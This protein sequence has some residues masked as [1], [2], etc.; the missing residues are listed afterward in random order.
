MT[1]CP[2]VEQPDQ[3]SATVRVTALGAILLVALAF[4]GVPDRG[5]VVIL[6]GSAIVTHIIIWKSIVRHPHRAIAMVTI[7][8]VLA[9]ATSWVIPR[10][11]AAA[12]SAIAA[13]LVWCGV[14]FAGRALAILGAISSLGLAGSAIVHD[15]PLWVPIL[16]VTIIAG[17]AH[18]QNAMALART[19]RVLGERLSEVMSI[20]GV[21]LHHRDLNKGIVESIV[22]PIEAMTG[23]SAG[24]WETIDHRG[25]I[26]PDDLADYWID[27][28]SARPGEVFDRTARYRHRN[29]SWVWLRDVSR[30]GV[31]ESGSFGLNGFTID[32]TPVRE[33][34]SAAEYRGTHDQ[35]TDL[36]NRATLLADLE[37]RQVGGSAFGLLFLDL[38]RF[39]EV[40]DTLGHQ[41]GDQLLVE[42]AHVLRRQIGSSELVARL[43][44]DEFAVVVEVSDDRSLRERAEQVAYAARQPIS[45]GSMSLAVS[46]SIGGV[47]AADDPIDV[48]TIMRWADIAMYDAKRHGRPYSS[49][50]TDLETSS[51][52]DLLLSAS[53]PG[54]L[55]A[56]EIIAHF[57]PKIDLQT[58]M[59]VGLEALAR[60]QHP[61]HGLLGAA[62]F[63]HLIRVSDYMSA[64]T[65]QMIDIALKATIALE[66][67]GTT[68][69]IAVNIAA[70]TL[71]DNGFPERVITRCQ[72][73]GVEPSR[74]TFE[75]TEDE[76]IEAGDGARQTIVQLHDA[77]IRFSVDDFGTGYSSFSLLPSMP[78]DEIKIDRSF[79]WGVDDE[80]RNEVI[81]ASIIGL[82]HGLGHR[83][84]AEGVETSKQLDFLIGLGCDVGQGYLFGRPVTLAEVLERATQLT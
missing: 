75:I 35:L 55:A 76:L 19:R 16:A 74:L 13:I 49:F 9:I 4:P 1:V 17:S 27:A 2:S 65:D 48:G 36:P 58:G 7:D 31:D 33:A 23:W 83:I 68:I 45:V 40:N 61:E 42:F 82:A 69:P 30:T 53:I 21:A 70:R 71:L 43:G 11:W 28:D 14:L 18:G 54:A 37:R 41:L 20:S 73:H 8:I 64:F 46:A 26:H 12:A 24:E 80:K 44:G 29:G 84:V 5:S 6:L 78:I 10:L 81:I 56:G 50:H 32:V 51:V 3:K 66:A 25:L 38:N 52:F 47:L 72:H 63:T 15:V 60:W 67:L 59:M 62:Q 57:Q 39:K 79:L 34:L 77:G 22:G